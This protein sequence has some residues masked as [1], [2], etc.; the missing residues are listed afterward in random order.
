MF[1]CLLIAS[2]HSNSVIKQQVA[3][4]DR[5]NYYALFA[6]FVNLLACIVFIYYVFQDDNILNVLE[7]KILETIEIIFL[8]HLVFAERFSSPFTPSTRCTTSCGWC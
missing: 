4:Q 7:E 2:V 1:V 6:I 5:K 8:F 3:R